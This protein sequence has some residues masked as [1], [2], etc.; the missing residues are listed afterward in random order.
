PDEERAIFLT[1]AALRDDIPESF[2]VTDEP[3]DRWHADK[4]PSKPGTKLSL[5]RSIRVEG[6]G[7][8]LKEFLVKTQSGTTFEETDFLATQIDDSIFAVT[9]DPLR[10][11]P[12]QIGRLFVI[13]KEG[14]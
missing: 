3:Q 5:R 2:T 9:M 4:T 7:L 10:L 11:E 12:G 1:L 13:S 8:T 14:F 6:M